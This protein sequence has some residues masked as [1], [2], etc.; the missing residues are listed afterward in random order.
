[1]E[2]VTQ[3]QPTEQEAVTE[4]EV[5][6]LPSDVEAQK[7]QEKALDFSLTD[8]IK[9]KY[10]TKDG[11]ILGKYESLDQLVESHKYLQDKHAMFVDDT[12]KQEKEVLSGVEQE[13]QEAVQ[14]ETIQRLLPQFME[15]GMQ[16]TDEMRAEVVKTGIDE[17][18]LEL[19][20]LKLKDKVNH[21]HELVGSK[22]NWENA[23]AYLAT[24]LSEEEF[25]KVNQ[26]LMGSHSDYT[27]L[28]MYSA[29]QQSLNGDT[30]PA[31]INGDSVTKTPEGYKNRQEL[32]KDRQ[33][34]NTQAGRKDAVAQERYRNKL[35]LTNLSELGI[36][37]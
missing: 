7:E 6:H 1:M 28:G 12:K 27:V 21:V 3:Q 9:E 15:N 16:L 17:R 30:P 37:A 32:F 23:K 26:D 19:G 18:D 11:K 8:E 31:R 29:Y 2:E 5:S 33:Y 22:E 25:K 34:L 14:Q 13:K 36:K 4:E 35:A 10:L 24:Q 20:A